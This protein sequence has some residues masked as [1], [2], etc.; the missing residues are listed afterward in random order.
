V[1]LHAAATAL[2]HTVGVKPF[3][4]EADEYER[5]LARAREQLGKDAFA[6]AWSTG[7]TLTLE[8]AIAEAL[9]LY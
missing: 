1:R 3:P 5:H 4:D 8:A 7:R 6:A 9:G 2:R